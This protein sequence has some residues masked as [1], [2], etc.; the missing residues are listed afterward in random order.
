MATPIRPVSKPH[1]QRCATNMSASDQP[2][3]QPEL[4]VARRAVAGLFPPFARCELLPVSER[5]TTLFPEELQSVANAVVLRRQEFVCGR[6]CA[7]AAMRALGV[8]DS[9]IPVSL[10][11]E[12]VWPQGV[13]GSISHTR[14]LAAAVVC[15]SDDAEAVGIVLERVDALDASLR[16]LVLTPDEM[17][18]VAAL[19]SADERA[20]VLL[21]CAKECVHKVV[22]PLVAYQ[23]ALQ[24]VVV[25]LDL[26]ASRFTATVH[27]SGGAGDVRTAAG[28]LTSLADHVAA[29]VW[30]GR[31][32]Q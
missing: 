22:A 6:A 1:A 29:G 10:T 23:L 12:P 31:S 24:E 30:L 21:F 25:V 8:D 5:C 15:H 3:R 26:E 7:H 16:R 27:P 2:D 20:A 14:D 4:D 17:V 32:A 18:Q 9:P 19:S 13:V 28:T 11:R